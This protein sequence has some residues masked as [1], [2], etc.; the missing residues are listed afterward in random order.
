M[1]RD[2]LVSSNKNLKV[3]INKSELIK[4]L[5]KIIPDIIDSKITYN[6]LVN[7]CNLSIVKNYTLIDASNPRTS[8]VPITWWYTKGYHKK[9]DLD[10]F[11]ELFLYGCENTDTIDIKLKSKYFLLKQ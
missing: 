3:K 1:I 8:N 4:W 5:F 10:K 7:F 6:Q 2:T 9:Y 11:L